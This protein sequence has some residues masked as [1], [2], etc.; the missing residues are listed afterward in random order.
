MFKVATNALRLALTELIGHHG[1]DVFEIE[2]AFGWSHAIVRK[3]L[4]PVVV[5]LHGTWHLNRRLLDPE[6]V[7]PGNYRREFWEGKGLRS[8]Q[9]VTSPSATVLDQTRAYY[10]L[11]FA[12]EVIRNPIETVPSA[13]MWNVNTCTRLTLLFVGRF[14]APKG[15]DL[16]LRSFTE[17]AALYPELKLTFVG[18]DVGI[19]SA[20]KR[21][22]FRKFVQANIPE[23][24]Q[25]RI[26]F[27]NVL[28]SADIARLRRESFLTIVA[29][30]QEVMPYSILEAMSVGCPLVAT[31]VGGIPEVIRHQYNG[32]LV[33]SQNTNAMTAAC[34][35]LLDDPA[36]AARLGYRAW[37]DCSN[38]FRPEKIAIDT[39]KAYE[40]AI[41]R[42]KF[43]NAA[44]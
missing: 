24:C 32:L 43:D 42:F 31:A 12:S 6:N 3:N 1:L 5:R 29:S 4:L 34:K 40:R 41:G 27:R 19:N 7:L 15:G 28:S 36:L 2:E 25:S 17:L 44:V 26:D 18:P 10:G 22:S 39:I 33:P 8:A 14:D 30:Q 35:T 13:A 38:L 21:L 11:E 16:V 23:W 9:L 37:H 20:N